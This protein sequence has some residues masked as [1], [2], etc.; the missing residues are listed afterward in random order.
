MVVQCVSNGFLGNALDATIACM[1]YGRAVGAVT[2]VVF[3]G[4]PDI[5]HGVYPW[6]VMG[7]SFAGGEVRFLEGATPPPG[8]VRR[9]SGHR[10]LDFNGRD[11]FLRQCTQDALK[12]SGGSIS[13]CD[14]YQNASSGVWQLKRDPTVNIEACFAWAPADMTHADW[15]ASFRQMGAALHAVWRRRMSA[16]ALT[17]PAC[18]L[19]VHLRLGIRV[20]ARKDATKEEERFHVGGGVM[21]AALR[22][23]SPSSLPLVVAID[24]S[25]RLSEA[26]GSSPWLQS[27]V[28]LRNMTALEAHFVLQGCRRLL[29]YA[30]SSFSWTAAAMAPNVSNYMMATNASGQKAKWYVGESNDG[31]AQVVASADVERR[32]ARA[33]ERAERIA[34]RIA[35]AAGGGQPPVAQ[36][37]GG[38]SAGGMAV[39][40]ASVPSRSGQAGKGPRAPSAATRSGLS[41]ATAAAPLAVASYPSC[42]GMTTRRADRADSASESIASDAALPA[43]DGT[44]IGSSGRWLPRTAHACGL[45]THYGSMGSGEGPSGRCSAVTQPWAE[46]CW[47]PDACRLEPFSAVGFCARVAREGLRILVV[48]DSISYLFY[49]ALLHQMDPSARIDDARGPGG[50]WHAGGTPREWWDPKAAGVG[51]A[52]SICGGRGSLLFRRNDQLTLDARDTFPERYD[53][54]RFV[55]GADVVILN[56]GAHVVPPAQYERELRETMGFLR[57]AVD[58]ALPRKKL[59][60][61]RSTPSGHP[62]CSLQTQP[63]TGARGGVRSALASSGMYNPKWKW[64]E[65]ASRDALAREMVES[66]PGGAFVNVTAM[67]MLRPD[68]HIGCTRFGTSCDCLHYHIPGPVDAWVQ[69]VSHIIGARTS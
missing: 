14:G 13:H 32:V 20:D 27:A 5:E 33:H 58:E 69:A 30:Y 42:P 47:R 28:V 18:D 29:T 34:G 25:S 3:E 44:T 48:G 52:L 61:F 11:G 62:D 45:R 4:L 2:W 16:E 19:G 53:W 10:C 46:L 17:A 37:G 31:F 24:D 40:M 57:R 64:D 65:F 68:G 26:L 23:M 43:C 55:P 39:A 15:I 8:L 7:W 9:R 59:V 60:V 51:G 50:Q 56:K 67:T 6:Q 49:Q 38:K 22:A 54:A 63:L 66:L 1:V 12:K 35:G 41:G 36:S 21:A